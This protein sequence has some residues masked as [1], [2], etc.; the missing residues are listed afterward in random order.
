MTIQVVPQPVT[1]PGVLPA[2]DVHREPVGRAV[3]WTATIH[4][5]RRPALRLR[6]RR[7]LGCP[8]LPDTRF[9]NVSSFEKELVTGL[10]SWAKKE[11]SQEM[12]DPTS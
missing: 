1:M 5:T 6:H 10:L 12:A 11:Y 3:V 2:P 9:G 8:A 4:R 7:R